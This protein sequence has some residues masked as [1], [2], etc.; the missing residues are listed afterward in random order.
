MKLS[1]ESRCAHY[2]V[3]TSTKTLDGLPYVCYGIAMTY[4]GATVTVEDIS[5]N[6]AEV[7]A[8]SERCN[9]LELSPLHFKEVL[10]DFMG[11]V[12]V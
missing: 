11:A 2:E 8:L 7:E 9:R 6:R 10:E 3:V 5:L 12:M 1:N 4:A